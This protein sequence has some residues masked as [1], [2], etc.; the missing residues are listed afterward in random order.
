MGSSL[1]NKSILAAQKRASPQV[2]NLRNIFA[3]ILK[4]SLIVWSIILLT[5]KVLRKIAFC[6]NTRVQ[7]H[8]WI[9]LI[10]FWSDNSKVFECFGTFLRL[11]TLCWTSFSLISGKL[12][13]VYISILP[14]PDLKETSS[15]W[16]AIFPRI[17]S[18]RHCLTNY[19]L[20]VPIIL[21]IFL[22]KFFWIDFWKKLYWDIRSFFFW[23]FIINLF[24]VD[25]LTAFPI[26]FQQGICQ[27]LLSINRHIPIVVN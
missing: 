20:R 27:I 22:N 11:N 15:L 9:W 1:Q 18:L 2:S 3:S 26:T 5:G 4:F 17:F 10:A 24:L 23:F 12:S 6:F 14:A 13:L 25:W 21:R 7:W 8:W 19:F 16:G